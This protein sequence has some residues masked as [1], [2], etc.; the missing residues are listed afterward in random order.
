MSSDQANHQP[1]PATRWTL[2]AKAGSDSEPAQR[3]KAIS[4]LC[5]TYWPPIYAFLRRAGNSQV[6][7]EDFT[8]GFFAEFLAQGNFSK[9]ARERGKELLL[10]LDAIDFEGRPLILEPIEATTPES[11]F[12][13]QWA[14]TFLNRVQETLRN[15]YLKKGTLDQF[16]ALRF[17][18]STNQDSLPCSEVALELEC[19]EGSVKV[20]AHRLRHRYQRVLRETIGETLLPGEEVDEELRDLMTAFA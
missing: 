19:S 14:L 12:E 11:A 18:I 4:E 16:E 10:S 3:E 6:E 8:Q 1:F 5:E 17:V 15:S 9:A 2:I 7:A 13:K 20:A